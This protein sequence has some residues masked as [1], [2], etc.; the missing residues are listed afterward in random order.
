MKGVGMG[1]TICQRIVNQ[2]GSEIKINSE[3]GKG[4]HFYFDLE[5]KVEEVPF[6][7]PSNRRSSKYVESDCSVEEEEEKEQ[8]VLPVKDALE[9]EYIISTLESH[10]PDAQCYESGSLH[11]RVGQLV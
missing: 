1:L 6:K 10:V 9:E 2:M 11:L 8:V 3:E 4:A 7:K 5:L